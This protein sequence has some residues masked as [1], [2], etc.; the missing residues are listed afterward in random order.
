ME[1]TD[2]RDTVQCRGSGGKAR[3]RTKARAIAHIK[4]MR[5]LY[6]IPHATGFGKDRPHLDTYR[7]DHC[8]DWHLT[9][10]KDREKERVAE[11]FRS[12]PQTKG[13]KC[14][15]FEEAERLAERIRQH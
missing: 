11:W 4:A 6:Q 3:H 15:T 9:S 14:R 12:R 10:L 1:P 13:P 5:R 8:G 2:T 7:C